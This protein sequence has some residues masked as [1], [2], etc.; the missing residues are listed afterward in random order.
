V[1]DIRLLREDPDR[2][3]EGARR[4]HFPDRAEAVDRAL[5]VDEELRALLPELEG[6][7]AEQKKASKEIGRLP[8][9]EREERLGEQKV[10]KERIQG[11]EDQERE[12]RT[13]LDR[14]LM[15]LPQVPDPEVPEGKDDSFN[16]EVRRVGELPT[17]EGFEPRAHDDLAVAQG[18][19]DT[20]RAAMLAGSRN[21]MLFGDL[22]LLHDAV[23][24]M[25][26]EHMVQKGFVPVDRAAA[27]ARRGDVWHGLLPRRRGADLPL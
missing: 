22:A 2:V 5:A 17:F 8:P 15:L 3:R 21:Y 4:K 14:E 16:V 7:R 23:L 27:G 9:A 13:R 18:W 20:E 25:A 24:R 26:L 1:I 19:L 10:L 6:L 11:L 12:L